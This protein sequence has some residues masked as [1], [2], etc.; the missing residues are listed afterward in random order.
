MTPARAGQFIHISPTQDQA[1][2]YREYDGHPDKTSPEW[3]AGVHSPMLRRAFSIAGLR[4]AGD[5]TDVD[6]IFRVVGKATVWMESL[7]AGDEVSVLGP[8]GNCF[9]IHDRKPA[10]WMVAGGVGLPPLLWLSEALQAAGKRAVAFYG[11]QTAD[12]L[13]VTMNEIAPPTVDAG[14]ATLSCAEF[15][16][17]GTPVNTR[18]ESR[19]RP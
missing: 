18:S 10:V 19:T 1:T 17:N 8:L 2:A 15:A 6:V 14:W 4:P 9:P 3:Q 12:L 11:A 13:A 16:A 5:E 7:S